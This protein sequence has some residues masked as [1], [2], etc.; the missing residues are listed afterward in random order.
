MIFIPL[1]VIALLISGY[2]YRSTR[3][4]LSGGRRR[5]LFALRSL[6]IFI[7]L[8]L[9]I[10]PVLH[11]KRRITEE[12]QILILRDN[13]L[14]MELMRNNQSKSELI[15]AP[16]ESLI[17][18]FQNAGYTISEESFADGIRG[19]RGNSLLVK[20]LQELGESA[21]LTKLSGIVLASDGWLRDE[22][23]GLISRLGI[24]IY[25]IADSFRYQNPDL[26]IRDVKTN[27]Y[28]YRNENTLIQARIAAQNYRGPA[29]IHLWI[30]GTKAASRQITLE[31]SIE[32]LVDFEYRF[33]RTGFFNYHVELEALPEEQR[34]ENNQ[35]PGAVEVL[36][37]KELI[38]FFS[39]A[40][41]WDNKFILDAISGNPRWD[42]ESYLIRDGMAYQ[43]E[44]G[45]RLDAQ[46]RPAVIVIINNGNLSLNPNL[47]SFIKDNLQRGCGFYY[48]GMPL[49][50]LAAYLPLLPSNITNSYQGFIHLQPNALDFP[51]LNPLAE[52]QSKMPPVDYFY[53]TPAK[54]AQILATIANPQGSPAIGIKSQGE[55]R[56][57]GLSF[58]NLWRWQMQS[59]SGGYQKMMV[60]I[61][62]WLSN[63]AIGAYSAIYKNSYLQGEEVIIRLRAEDEIRSSDLDKNPLITIYDSEGN[64]LRRDFMSRSGEEYVYHTNL[65]EV[66]EYHFEIQEPDQN[67]SSS[68]SFV[69]SAMVAEERDFD[70]NLPLLNFIASQSNQ[71]RIILLNQAQTFSPPPA[72]IVYQDQSRDFALYR[73]WYVI[74]LFILSFCVELY[75]RRRWGL[76]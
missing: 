5:M 66:G 27:R 28:A 63:K 32:Q 33:D 35:M 64:E 46:S 13:S 68:G 37:E 12:P 40:P 16:L 73:R 39:D 69:I 74:A 18:A 50:D 8:S 72:K 24:P 52:E 2:F 10:S 26:M 30:E 56:V 17:H 75:F 31:P 4:E 29:K 45:Q 14:S 57:L 25:A 41:G 59:D 23:F 61:L 58:L 15:S 11:F 53:L 44:Q 38:M 48:Q 65:T 42:L 51:M 1:A 67:Q 21:D 60:N 19:E 76:L 70:F 47:S 49:M 7:L 55:S 22:D 43:G 62:T 20:S 3:P 34:L 71:G 6:S 54:N 9:L 36:S